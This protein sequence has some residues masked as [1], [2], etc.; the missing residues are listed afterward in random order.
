MSARSETMVKIVVGKKDEGKTAGI[1]ALFGR[2]PGAAGFA[3]VKVF[4]GS[5][6]IGYDI[7]DL[8]TG[9]RTPLARI[10]T[11]PK[12]WIQAG[13]RGP[14]TFF[15]AGFKA[16]D[17]IAARA[18]EKGASALF[19]DEVGMLEIRGGGLNATVRR[20]LA[21]GVDTYLAVRD[22]NVEKAAAVFDLGE[23]E[24]INAQKL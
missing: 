2:T 1:K 15:K 3:S 4:E 20:A 9:E 22:I 6:R 10:G 7:E 13:T 21:S 23:F 11:P 18:L 8:A 14:F 19:I 5:D 16:A 24:V 12:D 17:D